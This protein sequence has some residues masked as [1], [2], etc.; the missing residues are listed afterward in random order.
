MN[1]KELFIHEMGMITNGN[2]SP[3]SFS[4]EDNWKEILKDKDKSKLSEVK[5]KIDGKYSIYLYDAGKALTFYLAEKKKYKGY[6]DMRDEG[7]G[8]ARVAYSHSGLDR[9]FYKTMYENIFKYSKVKE[10]ISDVS[11]SD[12]AWTSYEKLAKDPLFDIQIIVNFTEYL[13]FTKKNFLK[14]EDKHRISIKLK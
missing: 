11:V 12:L 3:Q 7:A 4:D 5:T 9:G 13:P 8:K 14:T 1:F 2:D 6:I 10:V